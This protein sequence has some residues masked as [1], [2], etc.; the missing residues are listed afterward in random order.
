LGELF[1]DLASEHSLNTRQFGEC[2]EKLI[3]IPDNRSCFFMSII[4]LAK[5]VQLDRGIGA[6]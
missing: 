2:L 1:S 4:T 5:E 6:P 3:H